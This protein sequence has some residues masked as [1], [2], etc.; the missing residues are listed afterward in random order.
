MNINE[1]V[2]QLKYVPDA[3]LGPMSKSGSVPGYLVVAEMQRRASMRK[4]QAAR[5]NP[6]NSMSVRDQMMQSSM[7]QP[8]MMSAPSMNQAGA[9]R[10]AG[11]GTVRYND[12]G[13]VFGLPWL[14]GVPVR[15][16][17]TPT[18]V[19]AGLPALM[20][21]AEELRNAYPRTTIT[22][23]K[24]QFEEFSSPSEFA[25]EPERLKAQAELYRNRK[26]K[27]GDILLS[28][29][30]GMASSRRPDMAGAIAEGGIA[31]LGNWAS[32]RNRNQSLADATDRQRLAVMEQIQ[33]SKD[34]GT[35]ELGE[36]YRAAQAGDNTAIATL[37]AAERAQYNAALNQQQGNLDRRTQADIA[38][39][40]R[41][42]QADKWDADRSL[43]IWKQRE[44]NR[45]ND[46]N[47]KSRERTAYIKGIKKAASGS[48]DK[49]EAAFKKIYDSIYEK[50]RS[51]DPFA[52][53]QELD[54]R[55]RKRLRMNRDEETTKY[56]GPDPKDT[57]APEVEKTKWQ[58]LASGIG[59]LL[60]GDMFSIPKR[61]GEP[62]KV[63]Y[64]QTADKTVYNKIENR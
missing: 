23:I 62:I 38:A 41:K 55:V 57:S 37:A 3:Q 50:E 58:K 4:A 25:G 44:Q 21:T 16:A 53:P 43:D 18:F 6:E 60:D 1:I 20:T 59:A 12:G 13:N 49:Q 7:P 40:N 39:A 2:E 10:Y 22:D 48:D 61:S 33:R 14:S 45:I 51:I 5:P 42:A 17:A 46:Q 32:E 24:K 64:G 47:N 26:T 52:S 34:I 15:P 63:P 36:L 19:P 8:Q 35:R 54:T 31:A 56:L 9:P 11:G 28:L 27:L 30:L 29:G